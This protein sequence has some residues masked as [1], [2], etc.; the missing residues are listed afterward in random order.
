MNEKLLAGLE[1]A[2]D[3]RGNEGVLEWAN[4]D[5]SAFYRTC[6]GL[7]PSKMETTVQTVSIFAELDL[8][9]ERQFREAF[10]LARSVIEPDEV[11]AIDVTP[12]PVPEP[13]EPSDE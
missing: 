2:Y 9:D 7:I 13:E 1:Y 11:P 12:E 6:A 10:A 3:K 8:Q 5:P 4:N